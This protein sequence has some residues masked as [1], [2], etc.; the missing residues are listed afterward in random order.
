MRSLVFI[1]TLFFLAPL[2]RAN[3]S[4]TP[5]DFV[6][7]ENG[8]AAA[9]LVDQEDAEV[10]GIAA[11]L[12][13]RDIERVSG[14]RATV[15]HRLEKQSAP[16]IVIGT[17]EKS[18]LIRDL[19]KRGKIDIRNIEGKWETFLVATVPNPFP[20]VP[21]ALVIAGSDRR[22]AAYGAMT[23]S[24]AIGV[25]P[26]EWWADV[27][28]Q[29]RP[30]A[31]LLA[32]AQTQGPP[33][34]KYRGIFINDE[35][36]G[37]Q[38]WAEK[39]FESG[40]GEVRD[41]GP[42]TYAKVFELL[43]RLKANYLWPA[44]HP[45]TKAFNHYPENKAVADRLRH[46]HGLLAL[47][48]RCCATTWTS[49]RTTKTND[50]NPV[51]NLPGILEYWEQR[52]RGERPI[53][54]RLYRRHAR[55]PRQRQCRRRHDRGEARAAGEDHRPSAR[56]AR[57]TRQPRPAQVP[58][59]FVPYK[60]VL[61]IYHAGLKVP[62]DITIVWPDDNFGYIR[63][64][65]DAA[66][67]KRSGGSGVYYHISYWG[68]PHDYLWLESTPPALIWE[69]DDQGLRAGRRRVWVV[70]VG[71]IKPM[72]AGLTLFLQMAWDMK[73]Y[74]T[75]DVQQKFLRDFYAQQFGQKHAEEIAD[76]KDEY[77]RLCAIRRPEHLGF[78]RVYAGKDVPNTP[79]RNSDWSP[80][81]SQRLLD[82]WLELS[83]R[84]E[85]MA[86]KLPPETRDAYF[87]LVEYPACAGAAMAE[88]IILAEK[89]R[90]T[91]SVEQASARR[92]RS[93]ASRN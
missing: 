63:Q 31:G 44:M 42:K 37:L 48:S 40:P 36:W 11:D 17:L 2:V 22:G 87:Q 47:P 5:S 56:N 43:L 6:L 72:E 38:K 75:P 58:Q 79:V 34:V 53:R 62:D 19:A 55:H 66:E 59:I 8:R 76:L 29:P 23:V 26:W 32:A 60:E 14:A 86:G 7:A 3:A 89:A 1:L 64:L 69:R 41:I 39:N 30:D 28:P 73:R 57:Q 9:I 85:A 70:N 35:D 84:A 77:F 82:R 45:G 33:S 91:G 46:R 78:N 81:E 80:D 27:P 18:A 71:D 51:T 16:V 4:A 25:S 65:P 12:L 74:A 50:W 24:E 54:E 52:V 83:R 21:S 61:D 88:K 90:L 93:S 10:V 92:R 67:R 68:G 20:G 13:S 49:G 15:A